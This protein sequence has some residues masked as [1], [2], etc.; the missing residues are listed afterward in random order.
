MTDEPKFLDLQGIHRATSMSVCVCKSP[1]C[2]PHLVLW[3]GDVP[4]CE[5]A[6]SI[7]MAQGII[8]DLTEIIKYKT[9]RK[10]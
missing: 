2:G 6:M 4:F 8:Q 1:D 9:G 5:G 10:Q 7:E 3:M